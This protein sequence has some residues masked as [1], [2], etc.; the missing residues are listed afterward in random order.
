MRRKLAALLAALMLLG[1]MGPALGAQDAQPAAQERTAFEEFGPWS[2]WTGEQ[3]DAAGSWNDEDWVKYWSDYE[4]WVWTQSEQY[5]DDYYT[6][7]AE[8]YGYDNDDA[9]AQAVRAHR[10]EMG[11]PYPDGINVSLNGEFLDFGDAAPVAVSGRTMVPFRAFLEKLGAQVT[12]EDGHITAVLPDGAVLEMDLNSTGLTATRDGGM[13]VL[14]MDVTPYVQGRRTY[15]PVRFA[16]EALGLDVM[17]D[18]DY[19]I[20]YLTDYQ[21]LLEELDGSFT[22]MNAILAANAAAVDLSR[23]YADRESFSVAGTLYGESR[24]DTATVAVS[25]SSLTSAKGMSGDYKLSIDLGGLRDTLF[26]VLPGEA[27]SLLD[28]LSGSTYSV[29]A[30]AEEGAFYFKG[31]GLGKLSGGR[32][33]DGGWIGCRTTPEDPVLR[34]LCLGGN[35]AN[36]VGGLVLENTY[37]YR[38]LY[39][40]SPYEQYMDA[41]KPYL[42]LL[43]DENFT[44]GGSGENKSY[45]MSL[46]LDALLKRARAMGLVDEYS[47]PMFL[48]Q[49]SG[50]TWKCTAQVTGGKLANISLQGGVK[51]KG[52]LPV[53]LA[54]SATGNA[55]RL[56]GSVDV[57]GTYIGKL[58][59]KLERQSAVSAKTVPA[60]PPAGE[61]VQDLEVLLG[62]REPGVPASFGA[63][64]Y[65][66][67]TMDARYQGKY[68]AAWLEAM[69]A[70]KSEVV[71]LRQTDLAA[72]AA[73][74][75]YY[76]DIYDLTAAQQEELADLM[77]QLF[78]KASYQVGKVK[79]EDGG[80]AVELEVTPLAFAVCF[81]EAYAAAQAEAEEKFA[82]MDYTDEDYEAYYNELYA[83]LTESFRTALEQAQYG[84][85]QSVSVLV[86]VGVDGSISMDRWAMD[87]VDGALFPSLYY[88]Y[89]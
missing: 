37:I 25:G 53:E 27:L 36:T 80:F 17:W 70:T 86:S 54:F 10:L 47:V 4:S 52:A 18:D 35:G 76:N 28:S 63:E 65:V 56:T 75:A 1:C 62:Y 68:D 43:G 50:F 51:L 12:Y 19:E 84:E 89:R 42:L 33:P 48:N 7:S 83:A 49:V 21:A 72:A 78:N 23:T 74:F 46:S 16:A 38:G 15:I 88:S 39:S 40:Q 3:K 14:E 64:N 82:D 26:S 41:V 71:E 44:V 20:A 13:D 67:C 58:E 9:W 60:A 66:R 81:N 29:I 24:N 77:R 61:R 34:S 79:S 69:G 5:Y 45:T 6:W 73:G 30:N 11:L 85:A 55:D 87:N 31:S 59:M 2:G 22:S 32:L 8:H 57:K